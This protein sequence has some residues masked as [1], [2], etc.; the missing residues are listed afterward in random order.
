MDGWRLI[1]AVLST[2]DGSAITRVAPGVVGH[3]GDV[4][5]T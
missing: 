2:L 4:Q 1:G 3:F 5:V